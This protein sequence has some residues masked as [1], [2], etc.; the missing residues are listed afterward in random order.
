MP[1]GDDVEVFSV[2]REI[3]M[4]FQGPDEV[5]PEPRWGETVVGGVYREKIFGLGGPL[6]ATNRMITAEGRFVLQR[7]S[8]VATLLQ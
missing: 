1:Y 7:A 2:R 3:E 4:I 6:N 5:N 8:P